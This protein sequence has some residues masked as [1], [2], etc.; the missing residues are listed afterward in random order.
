MHVI[1]PYQVWAVGSCPYVGAGEIWNLGVRS[2]NPPGGSCE[3][4]VV[5]CSSLEEQKIAN[6]TT[7]TT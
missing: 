5:N 1:A 7:A 4:P 6:V 2:L 3:Q